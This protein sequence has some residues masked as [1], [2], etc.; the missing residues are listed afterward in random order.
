MQAAV[1]DAPGILGR[2][3][4]ARRELLDL[5]A[6]NRLISTPRGP[7]RGRKIEVV[8]ERSEEVFRLLVARAEG[9]VV[10]PG[11]R[12]RTRRDDRRRGVAPPGTARR[13]GAGRRDARPP[14]HR[15]AAPDPPDLRSASR[16]ASWRCTTTPRRTSRSRA[17]ASS[18]WPMGFLN[19]YESPSSDK[20]RYAPL[21]LIPVDLERPSA[22]SRFHL[23][24]PRRGHHDEPLAPGEAQGRV[25]HR[26]ARGPRNGRALAR[27]R[28]STPSRRP[29]PT[30]PAGR[31]CGTTWSSGSS[32]S[33]ST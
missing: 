7:S 19:W 14:P 4:R 17:S 26:P 21:L 23:R 3:E 13:G 18:T 10:P 1:A 32:P 16:P 2:I 28:T 11:P 24:L 12:A 15:P 5:S 30:G 33:P 20:A 9:D 8:D 6:R 29:S 27:R 31:S 22:A 25:R